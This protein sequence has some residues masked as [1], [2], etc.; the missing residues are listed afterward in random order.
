[1][2]T[3]PAHQV[4]KGR[5]ATLSDV[6]ASQAHYIAT[7]TT[8]ENVYLFVPN[9]IG[10]ARVILAALALYYM[11]FHPR[12]C[13]LLYG[14]STLLDAA[15]GYAARTLKQASQ[16]GAV[17]DMIV[18]RQDLCTTSCLLCYLA[19]AYPNYALLFQALISLDF[20]SHYMHMVSTLTTGSRHHKEIKEDV[21]RILRWYYKK[22]VLFTMCAGNE[23]FFVAL[24]LVKWDKTPLYTLLPYSLTTS[25]FFI[26]YVPRWMVHATFA[27][28]LATVTLPICVGK[29]IVNVVQAWKASKVLVGVDLRERALA[30]SKSS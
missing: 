22:P 26:E 18:D 5:R 1:M 6:D 7:K 11:P 21:S 13:T 14:A 9:L 25:P 3:K 29:N 15:D 10:Y 27:Q 28:T 4:V 12:Y 2:S 24:Y 20:S 8:D 16:F 30:Q 23:L 19:S 17:L